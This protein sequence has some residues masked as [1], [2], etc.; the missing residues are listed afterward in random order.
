MMEA[1]K[2]QYTVHKLKTWPEYFQA[3]WDKKKTADLRKDD[4][5]YQVGDILSLE[6][7]DPAN[8]RYSG[9]WITAEVRDIVRGEPWLMQ[10]GS[11]ALAR[12]L[13]VYQDGEK[14]GWRDADAHANIDRS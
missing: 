2:M 10:Q 14:R 11:L 1:N 7:Y 9:R 12:A 5:N 13:K 3:S 6:E 4:R 8:N